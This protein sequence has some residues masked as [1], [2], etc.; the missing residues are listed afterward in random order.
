MKRQFSI[1]LVFLTGVDPIDN[2]GLGTNG[3]AGD[4][5]DKL[6]P[7]P[8]S[9]AEW[10]QSRWCADYDNSGDVTIEDFAKWWSMV[11]LGETAWALFNPG[12]AW[13]PDVTK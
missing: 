3:P 7:V 12:V 6:K 2:P 5:Q 4:D 8:M 1:P 11:G 13:Y 10:A 9:F